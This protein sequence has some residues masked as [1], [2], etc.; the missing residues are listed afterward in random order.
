MQKV[1]RGPLEGA[2][3]LLS[4]LLGAPLRKENSKGDSNPAIPK[5]SIYPERRHKG[6]NKSQY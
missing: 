2:E 6:R 3:V 4:L 1:K 5:E